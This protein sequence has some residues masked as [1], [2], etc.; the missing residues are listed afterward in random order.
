MVDTRDI[1]TDP[2]D[3]TND[4]TTIQNGAKAYASILQVLS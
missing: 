1:K 3:S 4:G 2:D